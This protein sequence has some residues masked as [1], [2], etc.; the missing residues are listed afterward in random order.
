LQVDG[1]G[2]S[3]G[4]DDSHRVSWILVNVDY[5]KGDLVLEANNDSGEIENVQQYNANI[6][7]AAAVMCKPTY[8]IS[9]VDIVKNNTQVLSVS[10]AKNSTTQ[11]T[12]TQ[13]TNISSWDLMKAHF[14]SYTTFGLDLDSDS[15]WDTTFNVSDVQFQVDA[16]TDTILE[17]FSNETGLITS[18]DELFN[19]D[20]MQ[21]WLTTYYQQYIPLLVHGLIVDDASIPS[22]GSASITQNRLIVSELT[23]QLIVILLALAAVIVL[24][25]S[26]TLAA[27]A[28]AS[29]AGDPNKIFGLLLA[30]G[31]NPKSSIRSLLRS[32]AAADLKTLRRRIELANFQQTTF[33]TH[34]LE[35]AIGGKL[36]GSWNTELDDMQDTNS[37]EPIKLKT[38][39]SPLLHPVTRIII[40]VLLAGMIISLEVLLQR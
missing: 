26:F 39:R 23:C 33:K 15:P 10:S 17:I 28:A 18:S 19:T 2:A 40:L 31:A 6:G 30:T 14:A 9:N 20:S 38:I 12:R 24:C 34:G 3:T 35:S 29:I 5:S 27:G 11:P 32:I 16:Y 13:F 7:K 22:T 25:A 4:T 21:N 8:S 36:L 37:E 1:C